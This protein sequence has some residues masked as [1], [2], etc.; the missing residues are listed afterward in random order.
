VNH[1]FHEEEVLGKA[2][3]LPLVIRLLRYTRSYWPLVAVCVV[4]VLLMTAVTLALPLVYRKAIN[5]HIV[6]TYKSIELWK[7]KPD[8]RA[9]LLETAKDKLLAAT[10]IRVLISD[11]DFKALEPAIAVKIAREKAF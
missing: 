5:D 3:D 8:A 10:Q 9:E 7:L 11:H 4:L 2:I 1:E 6:T